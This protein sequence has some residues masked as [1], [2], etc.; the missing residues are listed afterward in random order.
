MCSS[1]RA[2]AWYWAERACRWVKRETS[3]VTGRVDATQ[4]AIVAQVSA[5]A[6]V[7]K[8][9]HEGWARTESCEGR[10]AWLRRTDVGWRATALVSCS[11]FREC[12]ALPLSTSR[13]ARTTRTFLLRS[14]PAA[15]PS[16]LGPCRHVPAR[17]AS[18]S[19][20]NTAAFGPGAFT[21]NVLSPGSRQD[22]RTCTVVPCMP[23]TARCSTACRDGSPAIAAVLRSWLF[24]PMP[25]PMLSTT[26]AHTCAYAPV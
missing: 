10:D 24:V 9:L 6:T 17:H 14:Q 3:D 8:E 16:P 26:V 15:Y 18:R 22:S 11:P 1:H 25:Q 13:S 12:R 21:T 19:C 7:V 2:V 23:V 4:K 20:I 5:F